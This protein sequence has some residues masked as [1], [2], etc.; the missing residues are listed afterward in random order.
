MEGSLVVTALP[1]LGAPFH[2]AKASTSRY[3]LPVEYIPLAVCY[4]HILFL[5]FYFVHTHGAVVS[6]WRRGS[7]SY[8]Y[9]ILYKFHSRRRSE[10]QTQLDRSCNMKGGRITDI[11][12]PRL[13]HRKILVF[14]LMLYF[15][16]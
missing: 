9:V 10:D 5:C 14:L 1:C 15:S 12:V 13:S 3:E 16:S 4:V 11:K 7:S 2:Y 6:N 8:P